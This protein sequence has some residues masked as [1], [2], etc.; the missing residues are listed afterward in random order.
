M[1][2]KTRTH[3]NDAEKVNLCSL[4]KHKVTQLAQATQHSRS[5]DDFGAG[6]P[7]CFCG[8]FDLAQQFDLAGTAAI[9]AGIGIAVKSTDRARRPTK[10]V[11]QITGLMPLG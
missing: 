10:S 2:A 1:G 9:T 6:F 3:A 7:Q 11:R 5:G 4:G 8:S